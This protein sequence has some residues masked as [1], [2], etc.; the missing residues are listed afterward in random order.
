[1]EF[2][3]AKNGIMD[4][5]NLQLRLLSLVFGLHIKSSAYLENRDNANVNLI[6]L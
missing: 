3:Q 6:G 1:M 5:W 2:I 4:S